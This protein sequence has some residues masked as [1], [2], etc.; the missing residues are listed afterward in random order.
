[1][2]GYKSRVLLTYSTCEEM[3]I[4]EKFL[5]KVGYAVDRAHGGPE[6]VRMALDVPYEIIVMTYCSNVDEMLASFKE[7]KDNPL[8]MY[9]PLLLVADELSHGDRI[10]ALDA[11][12]DDI[13]S[14]PVDPYEVVARLRSFR[15]ISIRAREILKKEETI[16]KHNKLLRNIIGNY[17]SPDIANELIKNPEKLSV[18]GGEIKTITTM[19]ADI[20]NFTSFSATHKPAEVVSLINEIFEEMT[21]IIF[22]YKGT[23]DNFMGDC[24]MAF[25]GAPQPTKDHAMLAVCC[26]NEMQ[27]HMALIRDRWEKDEYYRLGLGIGINS[28]QAIV[29]NIGHNKLKHYTAIGADVN[30]AARLE[31]LARRGSVL[32]SGNTY[33]LIKEHIITEEFQVDLK[34]FD[35]KNIAHNLLKIKHPIAVAKTVKVA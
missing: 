26:A 1:M 4:L 35:G 3:G 25:W 20:R 30:M 17:V 22:K 13:L 5:D 29:G 15:R 12:V 9:I 24:I 32:M 11:G 28:G 27:A 33:E 7:I 10:A 34:G 19:F 21:E 2:E 16:D 14:S 23:L 31:K 18:L 8:S 6:A